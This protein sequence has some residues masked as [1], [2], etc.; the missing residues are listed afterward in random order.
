MPTEGEKED[1][2]RISEVEASVAAILTSAYVGRLV[3]RPESE[4]VT[5]NIYRNMLR[6]LRKDGPFARSRG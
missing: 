2:R 6:E 3:N 4:A 1:R 5:V